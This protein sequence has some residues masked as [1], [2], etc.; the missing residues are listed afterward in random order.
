MPYAAGRM[1]ATIL[2]YAVPAGPLP[3][4]RGSVGAPSPAC[5]LRHTA[6]GIRSR[7][8]S[9]SHWRRSGVGRHGRF[10]TLVTG[11]NSRQVL[12]C[13]FFTAGDE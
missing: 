3:H 13:N 5:G 8:R 2:D 12:F 1:P 7:H 11:Q 6:Y 10:Q 4:C 9:E